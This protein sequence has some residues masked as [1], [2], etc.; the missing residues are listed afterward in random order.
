MSTSLAIF[1]PKLKVWFRDID[2]NYVYVLCDLD[3]REAIEKQ[4]REYKMIKI[5]WETR[6][7]SRFIKIEPITKVNAVEHFILIQDPRVRRIILDRE[8]CM[9][10]YHANFFRSVNG[11]KNYLDGQKVSYKDY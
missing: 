1:T 5:E 7:C 10:K 6:S 9:R 2:N 4:L 3:K 8:E 11:I